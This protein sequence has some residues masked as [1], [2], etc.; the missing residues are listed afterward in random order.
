MLRS[1]DVCMVRV[2]ISPDIIGS[3][4]EVLGGKEVLHLLPVEGK[5]DSKSKYRAE[6]DKALVQVEFLINEAKKEEVESVKESNIPPLSVPMDH[7]VKEIEKNYHR[8]IQLS[9]LTKETLK[10][11]EKE[12]EDVIVLQEIQKIME[13]STKGTEFDMEMRSK[14]GLDYVSGVLSKGKLLTLERFLWKSLHGNLYFLPVEMPEKTKAGFICFTHGEK[15]IERVRNIC[16]KIEAR[17]VRY[18]NRTKTK[19]D[20]DLLELSNNLAQLTKLHEINECTLRSKIQVIGREV[21]RWKYYVLREIEIEEAKEKFEINKE[22]SYLTGH[23]FILRK[24]EEKFGRTIKKICENHGDIAAEIIPIPDETVRPTHFSTSKVTKGF[25][26]LTNVYGIPKYKEIN[27][28]IFNISTFPFLFGAM[29]GDVGH[30][31][32]ILF[33]GMY[34]IRK[35]KN[36]SIPKFLEIVMEGRYVMVLMGIWSMYFGALYGD[37][38]GM[39]VGFS[40]SAYV[41]GE[42]RRACLFG[43][44]LAWYLSRSTGETFINSLKMKTSVVIGFFHLLFGMVLGGFNAQYQ[45]DYA[46]LFGIVIPQIVIFCCIIGYL[47]FLILLKWS[48]GYMEWPSIISVVI[49][50]VSFSSVHEKE[51]MYVGQN[52]VQMALMIIVVLTIPWMFTFAPIYRLRKK[53]SEEAPMDIWMHTIIEGIEFL[54]GLISNISSYLRLWAVSLAH[55]ELS[56]ILFEKT[57]GAEDLSIPVRILFAPLWFIGTIIFLICLEGLSS[58]LHSLRLHWVEFGSKFYKGNGTLFAPFTFRP[59]ILLDPER[60]K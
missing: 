51:R 31:L 47:V 49:Q 28:T 16:E 6:M 15:A 13:E 41:D 25:Q 19:K 9:Q 7:L 55:S 11:V 42:K 53:K 30:G 54:M 4:L 14:I 40:P 26:E 37:I 21:N 12:R 45:K 3:A 50:M 5:K 29:F 32:I 35:E 43:I 34:L 22:S 60:E 27:P 38:F 10:R 20:K 59:S 23:G 2:Y 44:D 57:I 17:V 46:Q 8:T 52:Y 39:R 18:E 33:I 56:G 24:D 48:T 36:L 1:D 58:T